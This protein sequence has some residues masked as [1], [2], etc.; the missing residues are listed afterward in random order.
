[1]ITTDIPQFMGVHIRRR[2]DPA[3]MTGLGKYTAD[4]TL[5]GVLHLAIVRSP[6]G[7]AKIV[8][9]DKSQAEAMPGVVAVLTAEDINPHMAHPFPNFPMSEAYSVRRTPERY[10][11]AADRARY[12]GDPVAVVIAEDRYVAADAAERV[13]VDYEPLPVVIDPEG[14]LADDAPAIY[15]DWGS[16]LGFRWRHA[17]TDVDPIFAKA[18]HV[19]ECRV[20]NQRVIGMAMEPRA[21][22]ADYDAEADSLT[23]WT[24]TQTP[25]RIRDAVADMLSL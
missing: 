8:G 15:E 7:H 11:L 13:M 17:S 14:A 19:I 16:N 25:H 6:Y 3:L 9:I 22:L 23:V 1:M 24:T 2:E 18:D 21:V 12:M 5:A 4:I 10:P 20:V